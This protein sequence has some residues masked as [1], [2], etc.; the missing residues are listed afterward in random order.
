MHTKKSLFLEF[1]KSKVF[2]EP[3][4][5]RLGSVL[6][7][8]LPLNSTGNLKQV[9]E[10]RRF[11]ANY[12]SGVFWSIDDSQWRFTSQVPH[13]RLVFLCFCRAFPA[14]LR[15]IMENS[16]GNDLRN[17]VIVGFPWND[18]M[19]GLAG[20]RSKTAGNEE[21]QKTAGL[22]QDEDEDEEAVNRVIF[23]FD[24]YLTCLRVLEGDPSWGTGIASS[25]P[26]REFR[27]F[28]VGEKLGNYWWIRSKNGRFL[29]RIVE[30]SEEER[31]KKRRYFEKVIDRL[32]LNNCTLS[33][34]VFRIRALYGRVLRYV[35]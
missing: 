4:S 26:D 16:G 19:Q 32:Y 9:Q 27:G 22:H 25:F 7:G 14:V 28:E 34:R 23:A 20:N 13:S 33:L 15:R 35:P 8:N 17:V 24:Q 31:A 2:G 1:H 5:K 6:A 11:L 29:G 21:S 10:N 18:P 30:G 12:F 3:K